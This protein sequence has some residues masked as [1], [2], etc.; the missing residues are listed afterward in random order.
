MANTLSGN[1]WFVDTNGSIPSATRIQS[2][3]YIGNASG[4]AVLTSNDTTNNVWQGEGTLD[5]CDPQIEIHAPTGVTVTL[6]NSAKVYLYLA[7]RW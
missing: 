3:K 1:V 2:I 4:T 7:D 5:F 6:T